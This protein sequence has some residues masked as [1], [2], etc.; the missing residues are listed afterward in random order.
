M[1]VWIGVWLALVGGLKPAAQIGAPPKSPASVAAPAAPAMPPVDDKSP[2]PLRAWHATIHDDAAALGRVL[3]AGFPMDAPIAW[4]DVPPEFRREIDDRS[5]LTQYAATTDS[6]AA[7]Q[8]LLERGASAQIRDTEQHNLA[9]LA[10]KSPRVI[11]LLQKRKFKMAVQDENGE[12]PLHWAVYSYRPGSQASMEVVKLLMRDKAL[13]KLRNQRKQTAA[14]AAEDCTDCR[15]LLE[16]LDPQRLVAAAKEEAR[17]AAA[18]AKWEKEQAKTAWSSCG[19][20]GLWFGSQILEKGMDT[21]DLTLVRCALTQEKGRLVNPAR[22]DKVNY[23]SHYKNRAVIDLIVDHAPAD[24]LQEEARG[25]NALYALIHT[26]EEETDPAWVRKLL[27]KGVSAKATTPT[28]ESAADLA[29]RVAADPVVALLGGNPAHARFKPG[30]AAWEY[31]VN[32]VTVLRTCAQGA[33]VRQGNRIGYVAYASLEATK[34]APVVSTSS[35]SPSA[36]SAP[37]PDTLN[38]HEQRLYN[39]LKE[40]DQNMANLHKLGGTGQAASSINGYRCARPG[41]DCTPTYQG[42]GESGSSAWRNSNIRDKLRE[43][44]AERERVA[45]E[46]MGSIDWRRGQK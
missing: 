17:K 41:V 43:L 44:E 7:L 40:I 34:N 33:R 37:P 18:R 31:G 28:S 11:A 10:A 24:V 36:P 42:G 8:L 12:P 6:A 2:L 32:P 4:R 14:D 29:C 27:A 20:E 16:I 35:S 45:A 39:R 38:A 9:Y 23:L 1:H 13:L 15:P 22:R 21:G 25:I 26:M 46:L 5:T 30:Q 19:L 3:D